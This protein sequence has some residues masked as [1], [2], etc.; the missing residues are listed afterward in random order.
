MASS[1]CSRLDPRWRVLD[2]LGLLEVL[3]RIR[4]AL[5]AKAMDEDSGGDCSHEATDGGDYWASGGLLSCPGVFVSD[6]GT[7]TLLL[8]RLRDRN[9]KIEADIVPFN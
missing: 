7:T 8:L 2:S 6:H 5:E 3:V 4:S 9:A 1:R